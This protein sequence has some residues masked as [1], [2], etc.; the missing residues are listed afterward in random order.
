MI[1]F[2]WH[3][4]CSKTV[5]PGQECTLSHAS[6]CQYFSYFFNFNSVILGY[7]VVFRIYHNTMRMSSKS[8]SSHALW[9]WQNYISKFRFHSDLKIQSD[10]NQLSIWVSQT[11]IRLEKL[12]PVLALSLYE[13]PSLYVCRYLNLEYFAIFRKLIVHLID[14]YLLI[15][16]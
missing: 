10:L 9:D 16:H 4:R 6:S 3:W 15:T 14:L 13:S 7:K 2:P 12:Y 1:S 8:L 5:N 11:W